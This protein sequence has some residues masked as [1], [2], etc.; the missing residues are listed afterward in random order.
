[1]A[2]HELIFLVYGARAY[3]LDIHNRRLSGD[4]TSGLVQNIDL[5]NRVV[6]RVDRQIM[7]QPLVTLVPLGKSLMPS[8]VR[9]LAQST[10]V[11]ANVSQAYDRVR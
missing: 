10:A 3:L 11:A 9:I 8:K 2:V 1:M 7:D 4:T 6:E 5:A